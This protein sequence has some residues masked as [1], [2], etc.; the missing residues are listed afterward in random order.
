MWRKPASQASWIWVCCLALGTVLEHLGQ[1]FFQPNTRETWEHTAQ[2]PALYK[3]SAQ[4][5][6]L[7]RS[8]MQE[9]EIT[10]EPATC[11]VCLTSFVN[12]VFFIYL[13]THLFFYRFFEYLLYATY[14]NTKNFSFSNTFS[15]AT[16]WLV[17]LLK[18]TYFCT[19][20]Q[21][22]L[23]SKDSLLCLSLFNIRSSATKI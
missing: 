6:L 1:V 11:S 9:T 17:G 22:F 3:A 8:G 5:V 19:D 2:Y 21:F 23:T 7:P 14:W 13:H 4:S 10:G 18:R 12:K 16:S 15:I 20:A